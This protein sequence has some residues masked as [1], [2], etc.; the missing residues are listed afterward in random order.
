MRELREHE[1]HVWQTSLDESPAVVE[2]IGFTLSAD[3]RARAD[4]FCFDRDRR[5]FVACRALLREILAAYTG[6]RA[7]D[8]RFRYG[9]RGKPA[10][11]S[12]E[13][14]RFNLSHSHGHAVYAVTRGRE[15]GVDLERIRPLSGADRI[16][17]RFFSEPE[18]KE[19]QAVPAEARLSSF[20]TCWTRKEAYVKARGEGLGHP[21]DS[22]AV[23][24]GPETPAR[25]S[26]VG[27]HDAGE[28]A[29]WSLAG[30]AQEPGYVAALAVEGHGWKLSSA[31]W[32]RSR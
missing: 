14:I 3:E 8:L 9:H 32:P 17:E 10:L 30:L 19:L 23:T 7:Q 5:R 15:V 24:L 4:R 12:G 18:V 28:I 31:W 2:E 22:F 20:F 1:V 29:R 6:R 13:A 27:G 26:P 25:I 11:E 16:A 21:L